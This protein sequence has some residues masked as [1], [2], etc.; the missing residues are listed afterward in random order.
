MKKQI[1]NYLFL[2][3]IAGLIIFLDQWSKDW[4]RENLAMGETYCVIDSICDEARFV[5]WFN[6]GVAFGLFQGNGDLFKITSSI[7]VLVIIAFYSQIPDKE[8]L[9][10]LALAF[11]V[12]GAIGNLVDRFAIGHV[13]DFIAVGNF[14]V[15]NLADASIN[16]GIAFML[17]S[18]LLDY[19]KE[20]KEKQN[21]Q[22]V[23]NESNAG[24]NAEVEMP[25]D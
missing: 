12:G 23:T 9:L 25:S 15:F 2:I 18:L 5:H 11:E 7:I 21:P 1:R 24:S 14:A 19:L 6:T 10:R 16:I 22:T 8:W 4:V 3:I 20:Q 13:T 17:L